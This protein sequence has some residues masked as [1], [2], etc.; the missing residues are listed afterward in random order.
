MSNAWLF[1]AR[2]RWAICALILTLFAATNLPWQLDDF[3]QAKQAYTSY[4][5]V[6]QGH[7]LYQHTPNESVAT[8]PPLAGWSSALF[9]AITRAWDVA[10]R[11]PSWLAAI[12]L[13]GTLAKAAGKFYGALPSL[14]ALS[15][16]GLNLFS[17]RLATLVRTDMPLA[18]VIFL[19]GLQIFR[20]IRRVEKWSLRDQTI[21]FALLTAAMLIKGPIVYA[22]ILPGLIAYQLIALRRT[23][24][25]SAW[26]GWWPWI[27]SLAIF[28]AWAL[29]G[30]Y[31]VPGFYDHVVVREFAGRFRE[32]IH[33]S[34]PLYFYLPHLLHKFAPW[35]LLMVALVIAE[36]RAGNTRLREMLARLRPEMVWLVCWPL[37]GLLLMSLI[38]SK[39]VDRIFP[40][41]PPLC[42]LLAAQVALS[43]RSAVDSDRMRSWLAWTLVFAGIFSGIYCAGKVAGGYRENRDA[44]AHFG[45]DVRREVAAHH[46]RLGVAGGHE[47]GLLLY[48]RRDHFVERSEAIAEWRSGELN[49]LVIPDEQAGDWLKELPDARMHMQSASVQT[50]PRYALL[51]RAAALP[52]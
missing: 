49:A 35:S 14:I 5:M 12:V 27:A 44:L 40:V 1:E 8:K 28:L 26:C 33:R 37:A 36:W 22:F 9:F 52:P 6:R 18:L 47:E 42:L 39:R 4:E 30:I 48:C 11:L 43:S 10:W 31:G 20:K 15:A 21:A 38:P 41:V 51:V 2:T 32:G 24:A 23:G 29:G 7:W 13:L 46:W 45:H 50:T 19:I 16:F 17:P 3:D 25:A 34:Q